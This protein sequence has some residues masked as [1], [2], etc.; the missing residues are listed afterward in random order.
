[1]IDNDI[2]PK[3]A[4]LAPKKSIALPII[5]CCCNR[6]GQCL[7]AVWSK[8]PYLPFMSHF[9]SYKY[10]RFWW[11]RCHF[12]LSIVVAVTFME[13]IMLRK[14][15]NCRWNFDAIYHSSRD[16]YFWFRQP[17]PSRWSFIIEIV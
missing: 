12:R 11:P 3:I 6:P 5:D 9:Q 14:C 17:F 7:R 2:Q 1:V 4:R 16:K 10:F 8:I 15:R 13:P